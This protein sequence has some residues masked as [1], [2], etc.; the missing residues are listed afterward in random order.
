MLD[1]NE[2]GDDDL[3]IDD[4]SRILKHAGIPPATSLLFPEAGEAT[5]V[6]GTETLEEFSLE[7][8]RRRTFWQELVEDDS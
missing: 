6:V 7:E 2:S 5:V 8:L 1:L 3:S 4:R